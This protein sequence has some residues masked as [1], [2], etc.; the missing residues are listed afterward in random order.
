MSSGRDIT[1]TVETIQE[2]ER[3]LRELSSYLNKAAPNPPTE[4]TDW[5][6]KALRAARARGASDLERNRLMLDW[7]E[8]LK[9]AHDTGIPTERGRTAARIREQERLLQEF[10]IY[11][12]NAKVRPPLEEFELAHEACRAAKARGDSE[13]ECNQI[14]LDWLERQKKGHEADLSDG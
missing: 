6:R 3:R 13:V 7:L 8:Q 2:Q 5:L 9:E 1:G 4:E 12:S 10:T 14:M 11:F